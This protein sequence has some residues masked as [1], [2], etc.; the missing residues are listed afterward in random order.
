MNKLLRNF[1]FKIILLTTIIAV[2]SASIFYFLIP[3]EYYDSFPF[4]LLMFPVVS[5]ITHNLLLKSATK[6]LSKFNI[7]F[8]LSFIIKLFVYLAVSATIISLETEHKA[9][10]VISL[11]VI[12]ITYTVFDVKI[13]LDDIKKLNPK[14]SDS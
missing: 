1:I 10:F 13:V 12:Y 14:D 7:A 11:L 2:I 4:L 9:V 6:S 5:V 3:N 8:M